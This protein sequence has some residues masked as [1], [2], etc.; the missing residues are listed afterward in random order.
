MGTW[1]NLKPE[2]LRIIYFKIYKECLEI[3][4]VKFRFSKGQKREKKK[5]IK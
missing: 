3:I 1:V 2:P 5:P 4:R